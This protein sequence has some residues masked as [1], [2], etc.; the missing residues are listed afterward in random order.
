[1][2]DQE[3]G[4]RKIPVQVY[5]PSDSSGVNVP[6]SE[7]AHEKYPLLCFAHGYRVDPELY[8]NIW[9]ATVPAGY[10]MVLPETGEER[11]PSHMEY[12]WDIAFIVNHF[13][14]FADTSSTILSNRVDTIECIMGHSMGGGC[15]YLA[16]EWA[17]SIESTV[18]LAA[19]DTNPSAIKAA[20]TITVPSLVISGSK[21]KVTKPVN[22]QLP[23]Y[24]TLKSKEKV[25]INIL[26]G[27]HC[28]MHFK[29]ALCNIG[30][31]LMFSGRFISREKQH[32]IINRYMVP[33]LDCTLKND[34][35]AKSQI[36]NQLEKDKE[37]EY[38]MVL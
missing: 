36:I 32:E 30:E 35:D 11:F 6:V 28:Q 23:V 15:T 31:F 1:M 14:M 17:P 5:Y 7:K 10:I 37:I 38:Q 27:S 3:R 19:Y 13:A 2:I 12:A 21:D 9:E 20:S 4:G 26:G 24:N 16:V 33:W 22:H 8:K 25:W 18:T 29:K 34:P